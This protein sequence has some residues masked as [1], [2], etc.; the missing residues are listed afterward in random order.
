MHVCLADTIAHPC[1]DADKRAGG[2]R[3]E[4]WPDAAT[5][6][7]EL[8]DGG[9]GQRMIGVGLQGVFLTVRMD[10]H[11]VLAVVILCVEG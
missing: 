8:V 9:D 11:M 4:G 2:T 6:Q 10:G 3:V 1:T 5:V 7:E